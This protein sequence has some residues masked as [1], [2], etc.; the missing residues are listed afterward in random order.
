MRNVTTPIDSTD[1]ATIWTET[2]RQRWRD[3][4]AH[5]GKLGRTYGQQSK[6]YTE[7]VESLLNV[8]FG[9]LTGFD[10]MRVMPDTADLSMFVDTGSFVFGIIWH[11][12]RRHCTNEGCHAVIN[13]D[14]RAWTYSGN[15]PM[16]QGP[17]LPEGSLHEPS[18]PL[19]APAP[20]TWSTH[21]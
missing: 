11:P 15:G 8:T 16:C 1:T 14:G 20:G 19:W 9:L 21:S 4:L 18:Y 12:T 13:D 17:T 5:C 2:A 7:A 3:M 10:G 6:E